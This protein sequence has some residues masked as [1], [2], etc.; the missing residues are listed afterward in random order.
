MCNVERLDEAREWYYLMPQCKVS[1]SLAGSSPRRIEPGPTIAAGS[2]QRRTGPTV[3]PRPLSFQDARPG[4]DRAS[5]TSPLLS[6]P[7]NSNA[8]RIPVALG[9]P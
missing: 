4:F 8:L 3:A 7:A 6:T 9:D 1:G 5:T 2:Q